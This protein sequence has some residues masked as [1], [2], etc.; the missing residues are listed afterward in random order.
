MIHNSLIAKPYSAPIKIKL[1]TIYLK[2][3]I[4]SRF[5]QDKYNFFK[6]VLNGYSFFFDQK[7]CLDFHNLPS[8]SPLVSFFTF[9]W[10]SW[11]CST[12]VSHHTGYVNLVASI[13]Q[14][15]SYF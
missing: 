2:S 8:P 7:F 5:F 14:K 12:N 3:F 11:T 9:H 13:M 6:E 4:S 1:K 10:P 15:K